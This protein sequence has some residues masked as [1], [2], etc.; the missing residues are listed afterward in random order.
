M[1][2]KIDFSFQN[3]TRD[4]VFF[5]NFVGQK[6]HFLDFFK[7]VLVLI[8]KCF[9][10]VLDLEGLLMVVFFPAPKVDK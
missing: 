1:N 2:T 5:D 9:G 3:L 7:V 6:R 10:I 8:R 4:M